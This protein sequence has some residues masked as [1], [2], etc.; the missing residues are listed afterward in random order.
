M[1]L[2][3]N[4]KLTNNLDGYLIDAKNVKGTYV[5][6]TNYSDLA[7]LPSACVV[8]GTLAYV[9]NDGIDATENNGFW[10]YNGSNWIKKELELESNL[11]NI[12]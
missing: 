3:I 2:N 7:N 1:A 6:V 12:E 10:Q 5:V 11:E 9:S 4:T 8:K